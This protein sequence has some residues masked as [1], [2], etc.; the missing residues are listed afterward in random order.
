MMSHLYRCC[1][2]KA[3]V[4]RMINTRVEASEERTAARGVCSASTTFPF[5]FFKF[6][7]AAPGTTACCEDKQPKERRMLWR[8]YSK[9]PSFASAQLFR[10]DCNNIGA[11]SNSYLLPYPK[12]KMIDN[13]TIYT[14]TGLEIGHASMQGYRKTMEDNHIIETFDSLADHTL[15]AVLDGH[16]GSGASMHI[17]CR[18]LQV[19]EETSH[20]KLYCTLDDADKGNEKGLDA[21]SQALIQGYIDIDEELRLS[22]FMDSS[23]STAVCAVITP[24]HII[25]ANVGDSRCVIGIDPAVAV[26]MSEDHKPSLPDEEKRVKA[27][28]GFVKFDRINGELAMSR[29]LGDFQYKN[30]ALPVSEQII[31]CIPDIAIHKRSSLDKLVVLAC[32]G[33]WDVMS[34]SESISYLMEIIPKIPSSD[35]NSSNSSNSVGNNSEESALGLAE[36][37]IKLALNMGS[38]DNLSAIVV[39]LQSK[40]TRPR[41]RSNSLTIEKSVD[42]ASEATEPSSSKKRKV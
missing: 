36:S 16:A 8:P 1:I 21:I 42:E 27:A 18:L 31:T 12:T 28:G 35:N 10:M 33:I 4:S 23:G 6:E 34:N 38:T 25:C 24:T 13:E 41:S 22:D 14:N 29:A 40:L 11:Q 15:V 26:T 3:A 5:S 9:Q 7:H 2:D 32:D 20:W 30:K 17:S 37:L 39:K 19:I